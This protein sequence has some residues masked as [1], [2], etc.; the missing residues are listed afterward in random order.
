MRIY[1]DVE[2]LEQYHAGKGRIKPEEL[3]AYTR[4]VLAPEP[5]T[6]TE[7][8]R[9]YRLDCGHR[10]RIFGSKQWSR[11]EMYCLECSELALLASGSGQAASKA[12]R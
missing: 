3:A 12:A 5:V 7:S 2:L 11:A 4:G 10:V 1:C 6:N 9:E 8:G